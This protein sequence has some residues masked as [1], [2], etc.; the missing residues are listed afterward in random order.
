MTNTQKYNAAVVVAALSLLDTPG[1]SIDKLR[2]IREDQ[3]RFGI[4]DE[5]DQGYYDSILTAIEIMERPL[6]Q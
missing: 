5:V 3:I 1:M 6:F 2:Q 4:H